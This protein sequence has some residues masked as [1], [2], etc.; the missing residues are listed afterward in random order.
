MTACQ[1]FSQGGVGTSGMGLVLLNLRVE[2]EDRPKL[3]STFWLGRG[4][5]RRG[6]SQRGRDTAAG[7]SGERA[8]VEEALTVRAWSHAEQATELLNWY[9]RQPRATPAPKI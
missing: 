3:Q 1:R 5:S 6:E 7:S 9:W 2:S 8:P 4:G